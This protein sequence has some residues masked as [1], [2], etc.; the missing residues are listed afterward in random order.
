M[1]TIILLTISN[2]FPTLYFHE[3]L[4]WNHAVGFALIVVAVMFIF[5]GRKA[6]A[7]AVPAAAGQVAAQK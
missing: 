7:D 3:H 1:R 2:V 4:R 6:P 5:W